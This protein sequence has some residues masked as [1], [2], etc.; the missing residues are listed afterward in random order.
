MRI[1]VVSWNIWLG[2][3][4]S[5]VL[6]FLRKQNSD[7]IGLQELEADTDRDQAGQIAGELG[8]QY[9]FYPSFEGTVNTGKGDAVLS[10]YPIL[11]SRRHFLSPSVD[12]DSTPTTEPRIAVEASVSI[13]DS[14]LTVYSTHLAYA[15]HFAP[16]PAQAAQA[17]ALASLVRGREKV[18]LMG[19][20]NSLP[21]SDTVKTLT[22]ILRHADSNLS[23]PTF[24][25][26]PHE[27]QDH[28]SADL[29]DRVDY[30]FT[31][32]DL[33]VID[34]G[35]GMSLGSNHLPVWAILDG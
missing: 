4:Y 9:V 22:S 30:I 7:I 5:Q 19:D 10:R 6:D 32:I 26:Y 3:H 15:A 27:Y 25:M 29:R 11:N 23:A 1:K 24:T 18:V 17:E 31:S 14:T 2:K 21:E 35:V 13:D 20:L 33:R 34:A 16:S 8:Y 12:Y 28:K